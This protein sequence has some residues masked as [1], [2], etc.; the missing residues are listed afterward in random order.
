MQIHFKGRGIEENNWNEREKCTTLID[1]DERP[2]RRLGEKQKSVKEKECIA[3]R[4]WTLCEFFEDYDIRIF[5]SPTKK[6]EV[7]K[8]RH[9]SGC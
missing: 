8:E 4:M 3:H 6:G 9:L 7:I 2:R 1:K 5:L